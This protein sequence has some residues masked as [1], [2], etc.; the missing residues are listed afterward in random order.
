M[1]GCFIPELMCNEIGRLPFRVWIQYSDYYDYKWHN[2]NDNKAKIATNQEQL[3]MSEKEENWEPIYSW[4]Q[5]RMLRIEKQIAL[6]HH[7]K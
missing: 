7:G 3:L 1:S 6:S 2:D 4:H 5:F